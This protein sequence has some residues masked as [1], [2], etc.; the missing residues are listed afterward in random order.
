[1]VTP[2]IDA[3]LKERGFE[4]VLILGI[5]VCTHDFQCG[6]PP[7]ALQT[8]PRLID[9]HSQSHVCVLQTV[10]DLLGK[11][12]DVH[13]LADGVSSASKE[14]IPIAL[15]AM[16][17]AGARITTTE[18]CSFQLMGKCPCAPSVATCYRVLTP[19]TFQVRPLA[20]SSKSSL[21]LS[22]IIWKSHVIRCPS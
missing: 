22:R 7:L 20:P 8:A 21:L 2:Q 5:E 17:Q 3:L 16:R 4:S 11:G 6:V 18:S 19:C 10:L 12:Y 14:E 1:M 15:A 13:V 9:D